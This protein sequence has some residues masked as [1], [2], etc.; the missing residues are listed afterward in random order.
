MK[1]VLEEGGAAKVLEAV[2]PNSTPKQLQN[3]LRQQRQGYRISGKESTVA[4]GGLYA[5]RALRRGGRR[6]IGWSPPLATVLSF[7]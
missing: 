5:R 2:L 3:L 7:A 4:S 6:P 1:A